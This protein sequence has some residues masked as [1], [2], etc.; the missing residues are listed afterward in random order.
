MRKVRCLD[1]SGWKEELTI[2]KIYDVLEESDVLY[3][4]IVDGG[5]YVFTIKE[6]FEEVKEDMNYVMIDGK[7][8]ELSEETV[9]NLKEQ[10]NVKK[11]ELKRDINDKFAIHCATKE[12]ANELMRI[13]DDLGYMWFN[14]EKLIKEN[15]WTCHKDTSCYF[16]EEN[17]MIVYGSYNYFYN[18]SHN[19]IPFPY[20]KKHYI[21]EN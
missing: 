1:N 6:R 13:L 17:K 3:V 16:I 11:Y 14:N 2:G 15:C 10:L 5:K 12:H 9:K 7:K 20:F 18:T 8:I 21:K 19:I 4:V